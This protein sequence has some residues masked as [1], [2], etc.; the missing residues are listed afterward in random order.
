MDKNS[1][2]K[3]VNTV[4]RVYTKDDIMPHNKQCL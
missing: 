3:Y 1:I 4:Y 2:Y